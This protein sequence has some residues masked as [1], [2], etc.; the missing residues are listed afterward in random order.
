MHASSLRT[1]VGAS[2]QFPGTFL[3]EHWKGRTSTSVNR[4]EVD[5]ANLDSSLI[6]CSPRSVKM[7]SPRQ[8]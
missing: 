4:V 7:G 5:S 6:L 3:I 1:R 8:S 2:I